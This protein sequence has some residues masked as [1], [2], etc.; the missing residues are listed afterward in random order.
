MPRQVTVRAP[1]RLHFGLFALAATDGRQFG[2]VGVMVRQPGLILHVD[3]ADAWSVNGPFSQRIETAARCWQ[4]F[5]GLS[6]LP[7]CRIR[8]E[9]A[10]PEHVGLGV[11]TQL[12]LSVAAGLA[13]MRGIP[14]GAPQELAQSV[15]RGM[16]SAIGT[17]GFALGGLI[18]DQGK[19]PGESVSPLD[20]RLEFPAEWRF[21]L[22]RPTDA[23]GL[24]GDAETAAIEQITVAS[25]TSES[26][27]S[28][29]RE[30]LVPAVATGDF[31][32]FAASLFRYSRGAGSFYAEHQGGT[33]NGPV[34]TALVE[35][36]RSLGAEGVGQSS[37]GPTLFVAQRDD[38]SARQ[39]ADQLRREENGPELECIV[40]EPDNQGVSVQLSD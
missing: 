17:Y 12:A 28:E 21:L 18:V 11:G 14:S 3:A 39:L 40:A 30:N 9:H 35:R 31:A 33:Y 26:L 19:L 32:T 4:K 6:G 37:W 16:R 8:V 22:V 24:F 34:L 13:A 15:G 5:H 20:T 38:A 7:P 10:P 23:R 29:V 36:L 1:S 2:G 25:Q 27:V